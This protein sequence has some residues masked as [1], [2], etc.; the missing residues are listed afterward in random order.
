[1]RL[2][3]RRVSGAG[4][5]GAGTMCYTAGIKA[6][7]GRFRSRNL[8]VWAVWMFWNC[9]QWWFSVVVLCT[10]ALRWTG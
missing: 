6:Q 5:S 1:V 8:P 4:P 2:G 9:L 10:F 7:T 3:F